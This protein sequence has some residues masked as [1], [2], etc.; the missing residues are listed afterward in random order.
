MWNKLVP[1]IETLY[2]YVCYIY[3]LI[4]TRILKKLFQIKETSKI[5]IRGLSQRNNMI[6]MFQ[7]VAF[8]SII[9]IFVCEAS[10]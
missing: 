5:P 6:L 7:K 10:R 8:L 9:D 3:Y 4:I 1:Q 2:K